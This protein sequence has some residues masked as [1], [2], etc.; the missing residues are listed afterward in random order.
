VIL[1]GSLASTPSDERQN[2][3]AHG[4]LRLAKAFRLEKLFAADRVSL[5][6]AGKQ[7]VIELLSICPFVHTQS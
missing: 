5:A 4:G 2:E 6:D 1:G 3:R 7:L